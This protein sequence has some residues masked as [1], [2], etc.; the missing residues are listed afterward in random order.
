MKCPVLAHHVSDQRHAESTLIARSRSDYLL[1]VS[2][3]R[4]NRLVRTHGITALMKSQVSEMT[5][6]FDTQAALR[7]RPKETGY[8]TFV[9]STAGAEG[10]RG[11][12]ARLTCMRCVRLVRARR[13]LSEILGLPVTPAGDVARWLSLLPESRSPQQPGRRAP[14]RHFA[15]HRGPVNAIG[16]TLPGAAGQRSNPLRG[17]RRRPP[18]DGSRRCW[19]RPMTRPAQVADGRFRRFTPQGCAV[20]IVR[21]A[22]NETETRDSCSATDPQFEPAMARRSR[23]D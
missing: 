5:R 4:M 2:T 9:G 20:S 18:G 21:A 1:G 12:A 15:R 10:P 7:T 14:G 11:V 23:Q 17:Q 19:A 22:W 8:R 3:R 6:S 13:G 16:D